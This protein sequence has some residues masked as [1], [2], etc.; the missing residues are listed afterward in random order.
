MFGAACQAAI[1][2]TSDALADFRGRALLQQGRLFHELGPVIIRTRKG[3]SLN[4]LLSI[5]SLC[6]LLIT[7]PSRGAVHDNFQHLIQINKASLAHYLL[8]FSPA[9]SAAG[10]V[11]DSASTISPTSVRHWPMPISATSP[12]RTVI[13][14]VITILT[15]G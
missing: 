12:I 1:D 7:Q 13:W 2:G 15:S 3:R 5:A 8:A 4:K 6:A 10:C 9:A 11:R 14:A